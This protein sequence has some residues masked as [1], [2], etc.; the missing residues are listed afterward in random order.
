MPVCGIFS[1]F[2]MKKSQSA[3]F[4]FIYEKL[5]ILK[6]SGLVKQVDQ[7]VISVS[8]DTTFP[9]V[10][11]FFAGLRLFGHDIS[12]TRWIRWAWTREILVTGSLVLYWRILDS[13][14][15]GL[16]MLDLGLWKRRILTTWSLDA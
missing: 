9:T 1:L 15:P 3:F 11:S 6:K 8:L 10:C 7:T 4:T 14:S 16:N 5:P 12:K 2:F 13:G